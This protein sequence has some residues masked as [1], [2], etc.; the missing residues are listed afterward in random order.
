MVLILSTLILSTLLV[1]T[2]VPGSLGQSEQPKYGGTLVVVVGTEPVSY[3]IAYQFSYYGLGQVYNSLITYAMDETPVPELAESWTI[4]PDG[5]DYTF[6]LV[7]NATF[8]DGVPLTSADVKFSIENITIPFST[9]GKTVFKA[10]DS[11]ETPD[12]YTV[13]IKLKYPYAPLMAYIGLLSMVA[14]KH[15]YEGTDILKNPYNFKPVGSG[16]FVFSEWVH[17]DHVTMVKNTNYWRTDRP[18]LNAVVYKFVPDQASRSLAIETREADCSFGWGGI[19]FSDLRRLIE[20]PIKGLHADEEPMYYGEVSA[21]LL[22]IRN[23]PLDNVK[24]RQAINH[25]IDR[26]YIHNVG[27]GGLGTVVW[28]NIFPPTL[29]RFYDP[30]VEAALASQLAHNITLANQLLDDAGYPVGQSGTRFSLR[31]VYNPGSPKATIQAEIL[32]EEL[33]AVYIDAVPIVRDYATVKSMIAAWDFDI[34]TEGWGVGPDPNVLVGRFYDSNMIKHSNDVNVMG[35]NN[36]HVDEL[37]QLDA[38]ETN[39]T[40][41]KELWNEILSIV[42]PDSAMICVVQV[43]YPIIYWEEY[44]NLPPGPTFFEGYQDVWWVGGSA[45]V[46]S[47]VDRISSL[48]TKLD[49]ITNIAYS[50]IGVA[51]VAIIAAVVSLVW[52]K[53]RRRA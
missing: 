16:P 41:R 34:Y 48:E 44:R 21:Y 19:G 8:H 47:L 7:R 46:A 17:G 29:E 11:I 24:V 6:H 27:Y 12:D 52:I 42:I 2:T 18:Y 23:K 43:G 1:A 35:Y 4:S 51:I 13:T 15:L 10:L 3:C 45:P 28:S 53:K 5:T 25:A 38:K 33:K 22:N 50:A 36:S 39:Q 49:M 20:N 26:D 9:I 31:V 30:N 37:L 32:I 14:P 40:K